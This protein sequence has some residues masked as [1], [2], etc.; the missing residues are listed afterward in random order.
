MS[1]TLKEVMKGHVPAWLL[2]A[3]ILFVILGPQGVWRVI[4]RIFPPDD[5]V[6]VEQLATGLDK[7]ETRSAKIDLVLQNQRSI[8]SSIQNILVRVEAAKD[9]LDDIGARVSRL[10]LWRI[11]TGGTRSI[12]PLQAEPNQSP[13]PDQNP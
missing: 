4:D 5:V 8:I 6:K 12:R 13:R 3:V 1:D 9:R 11:Q 2:A 10:E 7:L